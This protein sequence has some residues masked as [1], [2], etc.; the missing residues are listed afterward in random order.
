MRGTRKDCKNINLNKIVFHYEKEEGT[1]N[2][3]DKD[4]IFIFLRFFLC[5]A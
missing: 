4:G 2:E 5:K 1:W 3:T